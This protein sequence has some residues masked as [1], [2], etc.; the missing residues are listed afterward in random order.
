MLRLAGRRLLCVVAALLVGA[1]LLVVPVD[2]V[3]AARSDFDLSLNGTGVMAVS[4]V[5]VPA[6]GTRFSVGSANVGAG[7]VRV[8]RFLESGVPDAS[9]SD[10]GDS[11]QLAVAGLAGFTRHTTLGL[12]GGATLFTFFRFLS[13]PTRSEVLLVRVD[14]TGVLDATF[15]TGGVAV[16]STPTCSSFN[17]ARDV[18]VDSAGG[19]V[20]VANQTVGSGCTGRTGYVL[21]VTAAGVMDTAWGSGGVRTF[22]SL[23]IRD[24]EAA[25][26]GRVIVL[27]EACGSANPCSGTVTYRLYKYL[28]NGSPEPG[29]SASGIVSNSSFSSNPFDIMWRPAN[30]HLPS[31]LSATGIAVMAVGELWH[32][33][34]TGALDPQRPNKVIGTGAFSVRT[35][36]GPDGRVYL[37]YPIQS[38]VAGGIRRTTHEGTIGDPSYSDDGRE[39]AFINGSEVFVAGFFFDGKGRIVGRTSFSDYVFR[40]RGQAPVP[41]TTPSADTV[42]VSPAVGEMVA[43]PVNTASGNLVHSEVDL[44][45]PAFGLTVT[46]TYNT[47]DA[48]PSPVGPRWRIGTGSSVAADTDGYRVTLVDG[49]PFRFVPDGAG[50]WV[51]PEGL[52]AQLEQDAASPSGGGTLPMLRLVFNDGRVDRYDTTGRL[53]EQINSDT[54]SATLSYDGNG[55]LSTV[56][57]ST[58]ESVGF[59]YDGSGRLSTLTPTSGNPVTY[60]YTA[61]GLL[62]SVTDVHG[63]I[64]TMA[65]TGDGRLETLTRPDGVVAMT[66]TYDAAGR[67]VNQTGPSGGVTT[68]AYDIANAV[69][70]VSDSVSGSST[71]YEHDST[72]RV[73]TIVDAYGKRVDRS[74]DS[75]GNLNTVIDRSDLIAAAVFDP[76]GNPVNVTD[77]ATGTTSYTYDTANRVTSVTEPGGAVTAYTYLGASRIPATVTDALNHTTTITHSNGLIASI[78]DPDGVVT[79]YTYDTQRRPHTVTDVYGNT[80]TTNYDTQGRV[81]SVVSPSGRTTTN[82]YDANGRLTSRTAPDGGVTAYTYNATGRILTVTDPTGVVTTNTYNPA[83]LLATTTNPAGHVTTYTYDGNGQLVA[84]TDPASGTTETGYGPLGRVTSSTDQADR[85]STYAYNANG[86]PTT[87][88]DHAGATV[89]TVYDTAGRP[90]KTID[91][92]AR[93]TITAYDPH[94]RIASVTAPG[95]LTTTYT[96]DA[97]GRVTTMTDPRGGTTTTTYTPGGRVATVTDPAGLVTTYTYDNAGR[98]ATVTAPGNR[99]TTY[100]YNAESELVTVQSPSGLTTT[101]T[102]DAAGRVATITDPAGVVTTQTWSTRGEL[103]TRKTGNEGTANFTYRPTGQ[104]ATVTDPAGATTTYDYDTRGNVT[105][106]TDADG[107]VATT[108]YNPANQILTQ[109]DPLNNTTTRAY[110][111]VGRLA[112]ITDPTGR[113]TTLTYNPDG[114]IATRQVLNGNTITYTYDG[115]GRVASTSDATGTTTYTY[116]PGGQLTSRTTPTGRTTSWS[117]DNA[118]RRTSLTYPDGNTNLYTYNTAGQLAS[119]TPTYRSADTFTAPN[120]TAPDPSKWQTALTAS[121]TASIQNNEA[122]LAWANVAGSTT[123]LTSLTTAA[124]DHDLNYRYQWS[125]TSASHVAKLTTT[126]RHSAN[127]NLR[128]EITNNSST[129]RIFKQVGATSTQLATFTVPVSTSARRLRVQAQ[130]TTVRVKVWADTTTEPTNWTKTVTNATGVTTPGTNHITINRTSGTGTIRLDNYQHNDPTNP[131]TPAVT[132]TYNTDGQ[133]TTETLPGGT[134]TR[135]YTNGRATTFT[136][137]LPGFTRTTTLT[138]DTTGRIKTDTT[139]GNTTTYSYDNAS[140]L[141]A[142][143]PTTGTPTTWTYDTLGRLAT[144]TNTSTTHHHYNA[145]SQLCWTATTNPTTPTCTSPP[146]GATTYTYDTA[147]RLTNHTTNPTNHTTYTYDPAGRLTDITTQTTGITTQQTRTHDHTGNLTTITTPNGTTTLDWDPTPIPQLLTLTNPT[148]TTT[149]TGSPHGWATARTGNTTHPLATDIY[150]STHQTTATTTLVRATNYTPYGQPT[151]GTNTHEPQLG[152][153]GELHTHTLIHLRNRDYNPTTTTFTTTDPIQGVPGTTTLTNPYHYANNQPLQNTDPL[154]LYSI[155]DQTLTSE[156]ISTPRQPQADYGFVQS[157]PNLGPYLVGASRLLVTG[158]SSTGLSLTPRLLTTVGPQAVTGGIIVATP[159]LLFG[160]SAGIMHHALVQHR[161]QWDYYRLTN[162]PAYLNAKLEAE[163]GGFTQLGNPY[164]DDDT[165]TP[166]PV[167]PTSTAGGSARSGGNNCATNSLWIDSGQFGAKVGKHA[168]DFGLDPSDPAA[169]AQIRSVIENIHASP[170]EVRQGAWNPN[171]G[172]GSDYCFYRLGDDVVVTKADGTFVTILRGGITNGWFHGATGG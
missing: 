160:P 68:F 149:L 27:T 100:N 62:E 39:R 20:L 16:V 52:N 7:W 81:T 114:T 25:E 49:S 9:Y 83:G 58:G 17:N 88:T 51:K 30:P 145:A 71:R 10:D 28:P 102:Y 59:T 91:A 171:G 50:G 73:L 21:R 42:G 163:I 135:T 24:I 94:G 84:T 142:A 166:T 155:T 143:T 29:F 107:G 4:G 75:G 79:S 154:G 150:G 6:P 64:T 123:K 63:G 110:D 70:T 19:V 148:T 77:P 45:R 78:T 53:I 144:T 48:S 99:T 95:N 74:Y 147:G 121:A 32:F 5:A 38:G 46:R 153:R 12:P 169:R 106:V 47:F 33:T 158:P 133:L 11:G 67:V 170:A 82:T 65:Y 26:D 43:D 126:L 60:S 35:Q 134:R 2:P 130:G 92:T 56:V 87:T 96:Y 141:T 40:F 161:A 22:A 165:P 146:A 93:E 137:T 140:Q 131:P 89:Q 44:E 159:L 66:N 31:H 15:G 118:G 167:P 41:V 14:A 117:V 104:L 80:A 164:Q 61:G 128:V 172:G 37:S 112:S 13:S 1:G 101:T 3:R 120:N 57:S 111:P 69:T 129:G 98:Q 55:R 152:Y 162:D 108:T 36:M 109:T 72:G 119:I 86:E 116:E 127:G 23:L 151:T 103:L 18:T 115:A 132:Y 122:V 54:A 136:A 34:A 105:S 139:N 157:P 85:T 97:L 8:Q 124:S 113:Q 156:P 76:A 138:Y 125:T 168:S 90:F